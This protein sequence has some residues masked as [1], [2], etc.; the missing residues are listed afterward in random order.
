MSISD[1]FSQAEFAA[2]HIASKSPIKPAMAIVL[3]SGL[4]GFADEMT[5]AVRISYNDIPH[6]ARSTAIG[7][8][9][10]LV[11]GNIGAWPVV[12]MQGRVHLYE[13]YPVHSVVFP[14]RVFSRMGVRAAILTNAA[15]GINLDYGQGRLV[16]IKDHINLQGQNP[17][18]GP[19]DPNLGLRFIDMTEAYSKS[20][21]QIALEAGKRLGIP[22][23]EGIYAAVLGPSYETP[24]EI[25]FLRAIGADLVGMSTV[26]EVIVARQMGIKVLAIS[27]VTNMAAGTTDAPINHEEVLEIGRKISG[28]FKALLR[29]VVPLIAQDATK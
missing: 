15:G 8:A 14:M 5:D 3:G 26:P 25:R 1:D 27:C 2:K 29:D 18:V 19:E 22:L 28:Q 16:V 13:G 9:G 7:H 23:G 24:A 20:Y 6:F 10:Q 12:V 4:G 21:R 17:L 11:L